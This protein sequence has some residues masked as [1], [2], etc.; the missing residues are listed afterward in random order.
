MGTGTPTQRC[1]SFRRSRRGIL[2]EGV[3]LGSDRSGKDC[4]DRRPREIEFGEDMVGDIVD[5]AKIEGYLARR[6]DGGLERSSRNRYPCALRVI[7]GK[8]QD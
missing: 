1:Q 3:Y 6:V 7:L 4:I 2:A 5:I 8:A